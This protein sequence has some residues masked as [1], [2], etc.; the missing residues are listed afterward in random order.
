MS[1]V[2]AHDG[3]ASTSVAA[4]SSTLTVVGTAGN[5]MILTIGMGTKT[6]TIS[7]I[8]DSASNAGWTVLVTHSSST[9]GSAAIAWNP[10]LT[11][12]I[13]S[14]TINYSGTT[15]TSMGYMDVSGLA[16]TVD[17]TPTGADNTSTQA[18]PAQAFTTTAADC[19]IVATLGIAS[20][21]ATLNSINSP[22]AQE[23]NATNSGGLINE[24]PATV[25]ETSSGTYTCTWNLSSAVVNSTAI[26]AFPVASTV[27][28]P[29]KGIYHT[30]MGLL[31]RP[32]KPPVV[33]YPRVAWR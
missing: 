30:S 16:G 33:R 31:N 32:P 28:P 25:E 12:S 11:S 7:S 13:T 24:I 22:F 9:A 20:G 10:N 14:V 4:S 21:G 26:A 2:I 17:G 15:R 5:A 27:V 19:F 23:V 3:N 29:K 1:A 8:T 6:R 18:S